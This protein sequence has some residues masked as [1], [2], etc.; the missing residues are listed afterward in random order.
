M[1]LRTRLTAA[2]VS[3]SDSSVALMCIYPA[4]LSM[5]TRAL[6]QLHAHHMQLHAWIDMQVSTSSARESTVC[7]AVAPAAATEL[8]V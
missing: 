2:V 1:H 6:V 4:A 5:G 7:S 8:H 3:F